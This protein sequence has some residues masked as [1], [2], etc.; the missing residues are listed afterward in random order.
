MRAVFGAEDEQRLGRLRE[1]LRR[2]TVWMNDP[3]N[4]A[5]LATFGPR[6][7]VRSRAYRAAMEPVESVEVARPVCGVLFKM[8][9]PVD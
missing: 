2:L 4:L 7:V 9:M 5:Q 6:W 8:M 3:R 1:L